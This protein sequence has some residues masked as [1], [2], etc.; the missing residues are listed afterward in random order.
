[1]TPALKSSPLGHFDANPRH[2]AWAAGLFDGDGC[3]HISKQTQPGRKAPDLSLVLVPGA[4]LHFDSPT[5][6]EN[7]GSPS[8]SDGHATYQ[9]AEPRCV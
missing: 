8:P 5:L 9:Q 6:P 7:P 2:L 1:M 3:V 4:K